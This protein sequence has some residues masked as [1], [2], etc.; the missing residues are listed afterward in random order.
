MFKLVVC[1]M[2]AI[3]V[4]GCKKPKTAESCGPLTVTIDGQP[5]PAMPNGLARKSV[6]TGDSNYEVQLFNHDK[7]TCEE[8]ISKQGRNVFEGEVSVRAFTGGEG[9]MG[10]GVGIEVH[11]QA[12]GDVEL[13]SGKPKAVGDVVQICADNVSFKPHMGRNQGKQIKING[14]LTGKY[15]GELN[16]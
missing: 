1:C 13:V 4:A 14:L 2:L 3:G 15:C 16:F 6:M 12:G 9:M 11:I 10:K 5:L 7:S 8:M